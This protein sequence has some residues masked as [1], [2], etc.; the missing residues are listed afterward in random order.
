MKL[1]VAGKQWGY[2]HHQ[3]H[4]LTVHQVHYELVLYV[5]HT[6]DVKRTELDPHTHYYYT[7]E[8]YYLAAVAEHLPAVNTV[9]AADH[10]LAAAEQGLHGGEH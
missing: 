2:D 10:L 5:H 7:V 1:H 6:V 3:H 8:S 9:H 4:K